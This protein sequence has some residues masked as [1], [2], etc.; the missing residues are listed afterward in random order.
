[1]SDEETRITAQTFDHFLSFRNAIFKPNDIYEVYKTK[2]IP[3]GAYNLK[4][5]KYTN[6]S[7]RASTN[8]WLKLVAA[9]SYLLLLLSSILLIIAK[10]SVA[11]GPTK[12]LYITYFK[13][14]NTTVTI[15]VS[16]L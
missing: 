11:T 16:F 14:L 6:E 5:T 1:M 13:E 10:L 12:H 4:S 2:T 7:R 9:P 3:N 8:T 15:K